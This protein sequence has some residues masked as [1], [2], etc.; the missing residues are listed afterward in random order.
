MPLTSELSSGSTAQRRAFVI[1]GMHRSGTSALTRM[2][3]LLGAALPSN[4][5][6]AQGDNPAGFW[7][8]QKVA[9]LNDEI[10]QALDSEWDDVFAFRPK[11]YL[12]NFDRFYL[13]RAAELVH[14]E[15]GKSEVIVLKDPRVSVLAKFWNRALVEAG[16]EPHYV[17]IVRNPL[18]VAQSLR[19]RDGF[20]REKSFLLWSSYMI[21]LERDT[22]GCPRT[23]VSYDQL[24][25]NWRAVRDAIKARTGFPFPR[26]TAA[27]SAEIDRFLD[28]QLRHYEASSEEL[29]S[30]TDVRNEIKD[31][32]RIL[33]SACMGADMDCDAIDSI[34][35]ELARIE[36]WMGP[37]MTD[38][39]AQARALSKNVCE[40]NEGY[41]TANARADNL[42]QQLEAER[43]LRK[44]DAENSSVILARH[45]G[46][47]NEL[48]TALAASEIER[49]ELAAKVDENHHEIGELVSRLS[50]AQAA[51]DH[52]ASESEAKS[53]RIAEMDAAI[54]ALE[55]ERARLHVEAAQ[56]EIQLAELSSRHAE[57]DL[58]LREARE[59]YK[60]DVRKFEAQVLKLRE[61]AAD[62]LGDLR[63]ARD[64]AAAARRELSSVQKQVDGLLSAVGEANEHLANARKES[65]AVE[66]ALGER[67]HELAKLGRALVEEE[68]RSRR[69]AQ[70]AQ[71]L[72]E[73]HRVMM[74]SNQ[75]W[76][77][78]MPPAWRKQRLHNA[79]TSAGLF[80]AD[81]YLQNNPDVARAAEDPLR[82]YLIHG[83]DEGRVI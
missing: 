7:E 19:A 15:F 70:Q 79:L 22:R 24:M 56:K 42:A 28:P 23:F 1:V 32:H 67:Y 8:P 30:R 17:I 25:N 53:T 45:E 78:W 38:L 11:S 37:L 33:F 74:N 50:Y 71:W 46:Q 41:A 73:V 55:A 4:L 76:H 40:L 6:A 77:S 54:S 65:E 58:Q 26:D 21:A 5:M 44:S 10:L 35:S 83:I 64:D 72:R 66:R 2:L 39:R 82:H 48:S 62:A 63:E 34:H 47:L 60:N 81:A 20:S 18:E 3:A 27:A 13:G 69:N 31:L 12:S 49:G 80:D 43:G 57:A 61:E 68:D 16:Y 9:D 29:Y 14:Q 59:R 36:E 52:L 51:N 75:W